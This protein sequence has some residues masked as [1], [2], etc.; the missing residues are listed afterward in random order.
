MV[1]SSIP[2]V[3]QLKML[4]RLNLGNTFMLASFMINVR[5]ISFQSSFSHRTSPILLMDIW[6]VAQKDYTAATVSCFTGKNKSEQIWI[7]SAPTVPFKNSF[8]S[9]KYFFDFLFPEKRYNCMDIILHPF[10]IW[11]VCHDLCFG[12]LVSCFCSLCSVQFDVAFASF[13]LIINSL[14]LLVY[15]QVK[16]N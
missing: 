16:L 12:S 1:A 11:Y 2:C 6:Q 8:H 10:H 3:N 15:R 14:L 9:E 7:P 13:V 4:I 5:F